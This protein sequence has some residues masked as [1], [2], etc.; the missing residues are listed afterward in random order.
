MTD[1]FVV[2]LKHVCA[3]VLLSVTVAKCVIDTCGWVK[4]LGVCQGEKTQRSQLGFLLGDS[5]YIDDQFHILIK[6]N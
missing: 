2:L 3:L 1:A 4:G 5:Q 6:M